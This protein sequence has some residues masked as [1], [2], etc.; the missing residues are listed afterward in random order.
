MTK[1]VL[2]HR[3]DRTYLIDGGLETTLVFHEGIDLPHFAASVLLG[4]EAGEETLR[5]YHRRYA[6]IARREGMPY[7]ID[8]PTW[9]ASREWGARLGY[10]RDGADALN[11]RGIALGREIQDEHDELETLVSAAIGP[12][13]DGYAPDSL[14]AADEAE[15]HHA[16]QVRVLA[17]AGA[18]LLNAL[19]MTHAGEAAGLA[20]AAAD[21]DVPI[22]VWMTVETD[23]RLPTGQPLGEAIEEIDAS[24]DGSVAFF[25][26]NCAHPDHFGPV[27]DGR[28]TERIRGVRANA[29]RCSHAE[30][31]EAEELDD[32]N[33]TELGT[34]T[35]SLRERLPRLNVIGGCCGTD[36]RH[37]DAMAGAFRRAA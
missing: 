30:L 26:I 29:S 11:T 36:H 33:P 3:S 25:G 19:T 31:D 20:R 5:A 1:T 12:R 4:D 17:G 6:A 23:G 9:R 22:A 2:P 16:S 13:G 27:L 34:L 14:M 18:D 8:A 35:A 7:I 21:A 32:G 24:S 28:W 15:A 37:V 10:T